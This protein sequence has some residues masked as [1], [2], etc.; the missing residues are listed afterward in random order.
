MA[1]TI[2]DNPSMAKYSDIMRRLISGVLILLIAAA[3]SLSCS[4]QP[5]SRFSPVLSDDFNDPASGWDVPTLPNGDS[6]AYDKGEYITLINGV[7]R[8]IWFRNSNP[9]YIQGDFSCEVDAG[10]ISGAGDDSECGIIFRGQN[11]DSYYLFRVKSSDRSYN[12]AKLLKGQWSTLKD[13]T[14]SD[15]IKGGTNTNKLGVTCIADSI[16][17][18]ANGS[19]LASVIDK[20][21]TSGYIAFE[22]GTWTNP[23]AR[24]KFDNFKLFT[25]KPSAAVPTTATATPA[26]STPSPVAPAAS[27]PVPAVPVKASSAFDDSALLKNRSLALVFQD[28]FSDPASAWSVGSSTGGGSAYDKGELSIWANNPDAGMSSKTE[29]YKMP[30]DFAAEVDVRKISGGPVS[31][32]G[33]AFRKNEDD[34]K[35]VLAILGDGRYACV[36]NLRGKRTYLMDAAG[37]GSIPL[38]DKAIRLGI[39]CVG[40]QIELYS[41]GNRIQALNDGTPLTGTMSLRLTVTT[42]AATG[43]RYNFDNFKVYSVK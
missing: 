22:L 27:V 35:Y 28:D 14:V 40:P 29:A 19:K 6:A 31:S 15:N 9:A 8:V 11:Y 39:I 37:A 21:F 24:Y 30:Q 17:V 43:A 42:D 3:F 10:N 38:G 34:D 4:A 36:K 1:F 33:L 20:S 18:S 5:D 25:I 7:S 16:E 12:L 13:W 41:N 2:V 23:S 26:A 32:I